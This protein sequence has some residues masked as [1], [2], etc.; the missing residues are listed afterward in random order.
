MSNEYLDEDGCPTDE[1]LNKI[2]QW[3][4]NDLGGW[5]DF[6]H[7]LW[8]MKTM[9]WHSEHKFDEDWDHW[10]TEYRASTGGWSGNESII[11]AMKQNKL[12]WHTIWFVSRRGGH[13]IFRI[14]DSDVN[15]K[16]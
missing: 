2:S 4:Y 10:Y 15:E 6:I 14:K 8:H 7:S 5:M 16:T 9:V 13:Y 3:D 1:A 12:L 11:E